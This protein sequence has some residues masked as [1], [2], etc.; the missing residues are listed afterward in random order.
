VVYEL[1]RA[2]VEL[3]HDVAIYTTDV[4]GTIRSAVP[5]GT[6]I[7]SHGVL[8]QYFRASDSRWFRSTD[9]R[10]ALVESRLEHDVIHSHNT[11]LALNRYAA[12]AH[13]WRR[14]PLFY[15]VHGA[16]DPLVV[17]RG[18]WKRLR[19]L[20]YIQVVERH[21]LNGAD[22]VFAL[23]SSEVDQI[24]H[25][26]VTAPISVVPNGIWLE[27][28]RAPAGQEAPESVRTGLAFRAR[29]GIQTD[30]QVIL[31]LGRIVPKK[32]VHVLLRAFAELHKDHPSVVLMLV[33]ARS[34]DS[35]YVRYL[36]SI[37]AENHI[38]TAVRWTDF[39]NETDKVGAWAAATLFS[40]VS[41]S[42]G[43]AMSVLE[44]MAAGLPVIVSR[45][46]YMSRAAAAGALI[47]IQNNAVEL[48]AA[49]ESLLAD[50]TLCRRLGETARK[51]VQ[52]HHA[53]SKIAQE[54][55]EVYHQA[56]VPAGAQL[57]IAGPQDRG[58][59]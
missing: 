48:R 9:L 10:R 46:C 27:E 7:R 35:D 51:Y 26:G 53:W 59:G 37:I 16:L 43:M 22:G 50:A 47:E 55:V 12:E 21:N 33:G 54:I 42:E 19:K 8:I 20:A 40:H 57:G 25:Y 28:G 45:E 30:Q 13:K 39:L 52:Q 4:N 38:Q 29:F 41:G 58:V 23:T 24:R 5:A 34:S 32:G 2:Q 1:A 14:R 31:Y 18:W 15:H 49:I 44:A 56:L 3:G 36:E 11:F 6:V 17:N